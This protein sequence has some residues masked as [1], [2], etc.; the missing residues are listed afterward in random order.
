MSIIFLAMSDIPDIFFE[1]AWFLLDSLGT[2]SL[3]TR[4]LSLPTLWEAFV[5]QTAD[6]KWSGDCIV[7][8][9]SQFGLLLSV[10]ALFCAK[11]GKFGKCTKAHYNMRCDHDYLCSGRHTSLLRAELPEGLVLTTCNCYLFL[12]FQIVNQAL[13]SIQMCWLWR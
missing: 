5:S 3:Q 12:P 1:K 4:T 7:L 2:K 10:G 8:V 6:D 11:G 13:E 9:G